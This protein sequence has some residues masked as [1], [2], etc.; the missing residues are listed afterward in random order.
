M[1]GVKKKDKLPEYSPQWE[2][3]T[4]PAQIINL[5]NRSKEDHDLINITLSGDKQIYHSSILRIQAQETTIL[6]DELVPASGHKHITPASR[7]Q[8]RLRCRGAEI[9]FLTRIKKISS[10]KGIA[11]YHADLP[12]SIHHLQRRE[13]FRIKTHSDSLQLT[14]PLA[15]SSIRGQLSDISR[16]GV[17]II[18]SAATSL[19]SG[20]FL[21]SCRLILPQEIIINGSLSIRSSRKG[22]VNNTLHIG[23][24]LSDISRQE[25]N[26]LDRYV[27][28]LERAL[29][30]RS[31]KV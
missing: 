25:R 13:Y 2:K 8:V 20:Q 24:I 5:L 31:Q 14:I 16:G 7:I 28:K 29:I 26:T 1:F 12:D 15:G 22:R 21:P 10:H 18:I 6:L 23:G 30:R 3:I 17:G 27:T 9:R 4:R 19:S 11:I